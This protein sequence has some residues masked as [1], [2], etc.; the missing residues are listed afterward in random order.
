M[1][2]FLFANF[3]PYKKAEPFLVNEFEFTKKHA[4]SVSVCTLYGKQEDKIIEN[5]AS[6]I[7][8][9]PV[10]DSPGNKMQLFLRG[11]FNLAP[12]GF[13]FK[14]LFSKALFFSPKK[15]YW[16]YISTLITRLALSSKTFK[17]ALQKIES[18]AQPVLYFYWG[19]N[20][21]WTIPYLKKKIKNKN[22]KIVLRLHG[23]DLYEHVKNDYA[24]LRKQLF[25]DVD[26]IA[27]VSE[28]GKN[29][30]AEKYPEFKNKL[31]VSRLG[32]NDNG[33]NKETRSSKE[34]NIISVSNVVPVKRVKL[35]FEALQQN[36]L[37]II[38]HHFGDGPL[39]QELK[40]LTTNARNEL[41]IILHGYV[42]NKDLMNFYKE[43]HIDLL[44][45]ASYSEGLPVSI[46]EALSFG[47][48]VIATNVGG[49]S[50]LADKHVGALIERDF[51]TK[52]LSESI[53][54]FF[55]LGDNEIEI[56]RKNARL[57]YTTVAN[58][59]KNYEAFYKKIKAI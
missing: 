59:E 36:N 43:N 19:D 2:V 42:S 23:S 16:F 17:E 33:L 32:V 48:P 53:V 57:R 25:S 18:S 58:A 31:L 40:E 28:N 41:K 34:L 35:I 55:K 11:T 8:L 21:A 10:L 20:L 52:E 47:I 3:F 24:P 13:H 4:T 27:T 12:F 38:W 14:E 49:T 56:R 15:F 51:K 30:L 39:L 29:Y 6:I 54:Q 45:N 44:I 22:L 46:M 7:L 9:P 1:D 5:S 26:I 50:E 37:N